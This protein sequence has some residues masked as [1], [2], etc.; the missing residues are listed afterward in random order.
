LRENPELIVIPPDFEHK[1]G[2]TWRSPQ[3]RS[4]FLNELLLGVTG[5]GKTVSVDRDL[6][7]YDQVI[8]HGMINNHRINIRQLVWLEV[9]AS[10]GPKDLAVTTFLAFDQALGT[11][12]YLRFRRMTEYEML[13]QVVNLMFIHAVG[14]LIIDEFQSLESPELLKFLLRLSNVSR[15]PVLGMGTYKVEKMFT[16]NAQLRVLR[17]Y[18]GG[19]PRWEPL[20]RTKEWPIYLAALWRYQVTR[21]PTKLGPELSDRLYEESQGIPDFASRI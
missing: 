10:K 21:T 1:P 6:D 5:G 2:G 19:T 7:Q 14:L 4:S 8:N 3:R 12:Y 17:R 20:E 16:E 9:E 15:T 18:F 11:N 13:L